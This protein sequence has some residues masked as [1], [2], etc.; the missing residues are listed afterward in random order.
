DKYLDELQGAYV[1]AAELA[2]DVGFDAVDVKACHGYLI[3]ELLA[4]RMR[5]G[6][7]GG[8]FE[9]RTRFLLEV[10]ARIRGELGAGRMV[11][12]RL[13]VY[14]A[15]PYPYGWGVDKDDCTRPDLAEPKKLL[16]LL[17]RRGVGM[18][19]ISAG[20]PYYNPHYGRPFNQPASGGY[21][22][23]GHPLIGVCRLI[24][25]AGEIQREFPDMAIVGTGYSWLRALLPN[26]AAA[27][28]RNGLAT[29]I[30]AGRMAFA[31]PDFAADILT[32]GKLDAKKVCIACGACTQMMRDGVMAGCVIRDN[33]LYGP[34]FE[35][36]RLGNRE[37]LLRLAR[38]CRQCQEATCSLACPAGIDIP[39]FM[40]L[41]IDGDERGAYE[42]IREANIF[43]EVC[44][45]LCPVAQ[46]CQGNCL[47]AFIG[48]GP[49]PIA[50]IQR[51]LAEQANENGWSRLRI[52]K[53]STGR[54]VAVIGA[55]PAGLACAAK[56]LESGHVVTVFDKTAR[57]GGL[58][59]AVIPPG[60]TGASLN[61]EIAAI[62]KDVPPDRLIWQ[63]GRELTARF[64]LDAI[65][66]EGFDAVF[67]S[68][69]LSQTTGISKRRLRGLHNA[70]GFLCAAKHGG[71]L[72]VAGK[73][74]AVIGGGNTAMDAAVTAKQLG[75]R[76]VYLIYRRSFAEM[77]AWPAER[78]CALSKGVH[79]LILTQPLEYLAEDD[80]LTGVKVCPTT[81]GEPDG[82]GRRRPIL[83]DRRAYELDVDVI[84]E[85]VS[86][87]A[88]ADL[89]EM[90]PGVEL[91]KGLIKTQAD[92]LM[93]SRERVWA[94]GDLVQGASTVV[95]AVADGMAASREIDRFLRQDATEGVR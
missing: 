76:D 24:K 3:S 27:S 30:G 48:D 41:F 53:E 47:E 5:E 31:Y 18:V 57:L 14:D 50:A 81:L 22:S 85:A 34:I 36:G 63:H 77:P 26:V 4:C 87:H 49:L 9:N 10:I 8:A 90:L 45:Y 52:P 35:R 25:L 7:Y 86:Q 89:G 23:P 79:F 13:G 56:L 65:M 67:V 16:A 44:A 69:G 46:Q 91:E 92:S 38:Q 75:A 60:R 68:F 74:V 1:R 39:R 95:A 28:K 93:T 84:V 62:F 19:N 61:N 37:N 58:I 33:E 88:P 70:L 2:F 43:P 94:G 11:V 17:Q 73:T 82:S 42:V 72:D 54:K 20:N 80:K 6:K 71:Q 64:N 21:E 83:L 15:I 29:F 55:G 40:G 78:D 66:S 32:K 12:T 59:E 51:Y